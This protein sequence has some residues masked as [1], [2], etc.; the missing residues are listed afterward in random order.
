MHTIIRFM[1]LPMLML[2]GLECHAALPYAHGTAP[3]EGVENQ[4][5]STYQA[6][7]AT[8]AV[9]R[10]LD[11]R[12]LLAP[13]QR[14][15]VFSPDGNRLAETAQGG[16]IQVRT[17]GLE[18]QAVR[19]TGHRNGVTAMAFSPASQRLLTAGG[20]LLVK[21]WDLDNSQL[22]YTL[23]GHAAPV[24]DAAFSSDGRFIL[25]ASDD[26]TV[27]L[28]D[29][30]SGRMLGGHQ[31][32]T[33]LLTFTPDRRYALSVDTD[34]PRLMRRWEV[35]TGKT[36]GYYQGHNKA[37][38]RMAYAPGGLRMATADAGGG[39]ILWEAQ[40]QTPISILEGHTAPI[41]EL[42]FS[43]DGTMLLSADRVQSW[44][45]WDARTGQPL[46]SV[47]APPGNI[48]A[49]TLHGGP[50]AKPL[51]LGERGM[52]RVWDSLGG[53]G[54]YSLLNPPTHD[55]MLPNQGVSLGMPPG[56]AG[57][58]VPGTWMHQNAAIAAPS[59][60]GEAPAFSGSGHGY[61]APAPGMPG[62]PALN[63]AGAV[64]TPASPPVEVQPGTALP[65]MHS[66]PPQDSGQN[67]GGATM[68]P[69][70]AQPAQS[71]SMPSG[72]L[73]NQGSTPHGLMP[74]APPAVQGKR[75]DQSSVY[76]PVA[77][78]ATPV[79]QG[80]VI[81]GPGHPTG[82][83][84]GRGVA[85]PERNKALGQVLTAPPIPGAV[86]AARPQVTPKHKTAIAIPA[87]EPVVTKKAETL[88]KKAPVW[89]KP[90]RPPAAPVNLVATVNPE[91]VPTQDTNSVV[92]ADTG[93]TFVEVPGGCF[94]MGGNDKNMT[95]AERPAHE[96]C[97]TPFW[98]SRFEVTQGQW[99]AVMKKNPS[100]FKLGPNYPVE[101]VSWEDA[102]SFVQKINRKVGQPYY[103]LP[104]EA[105][106]EYACRSGGKD[107]EYCG[108]DD[109]SA[110]GWHQGNGGLSTHAVGL[111]RP[112]GLGLFDMSG[113]VL[114]WTLDG[115]QE[116]YYTKSPRNNPSGPKVANHRA[117]RG[118]SWRTPPLDEARATM[119]H[120]LSPKL[121]HA[122]LGFRVIR[123]TPPRPAHTVVRRT[124]ERRAAA[125]TVEQLNIAQAQQ[126]NMINGI[127][128]FVTPQAGSMDPPPVILPT[129]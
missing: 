28:W 7:E 122:S 113:N 34:E 93:I 40:N 19:L 110:V 56:T 92:D 109:L 11:P 66:A 58:H 107:E 12:A 87:P 47:Q 67:R 108:G 91:T 31:R 104:T 50:P 46:Q 78:D 15:A 88:P 23:A 2:V 65:G 36:V 60:G 84:G 20:D 55:P 102:Q 6:P 71:F 94:S 18:D 116:N 10:N 27:R 81:P 72:M 57:P 16:G 33:R 96:V 3:P 8:K 101:Q 82:G 120:D 126:P 128:R 41:S 32:R 117:A 111:R 100:F 25:T 80:Q 39:I 105:Q 4:G 70:M 49:A 83:A 118:G 103:Q 89:V 86:L 48:L 45:L 77:L 125:I 73:P 35:V 26:G 119:R 44:I 76:R 106:W 9:Q 79:M 17:V 64:T 21:L 22:I 90:A 52:L 53:G 124:D 75:A 123:T 59:V 43:Q 1:L 37:I 38:T 63:G 14:E 74:A 69:P 114:E 24:R 54:A 127:P 129:P 112:N 115:F 97:L 98:M 85:I 61:G 5:V 62:G 121:R 42:V 13:P 99:A 51:F 95:P 68:A 30:E 29:T